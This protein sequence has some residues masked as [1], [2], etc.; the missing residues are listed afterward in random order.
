[1]TP[2]SGA[3]LTLCFKALGGNYCKVRE[4]DKTLACSI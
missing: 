3:K 1:M 2:Q 4:F